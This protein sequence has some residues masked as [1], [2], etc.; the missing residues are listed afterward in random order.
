MNVFSALSGGLGNQMFQYAAARSLAQRVGADLVI[1]TWSGF[2]RDHQYRRHYELGAF[3]IKGR[4]ARPWE[5]IPIWLHRA[6]VRAGFCP[7]QPI[8]DQWFGKFL[9][10]LPNTGSSPTDR[11]AVQFEYQPLF[12]QFTPSR[13]V[14]LLGYWQS[15]RYFEEISTALRME[16]MP[17]MPIR[18]SFRRLGEELSQCESVAL[19]V[20]L[21]EESANPGAHALH[22]RLKGVEEIRSAVSRVRAAHPSARIYVFCTHRSEILAQ[23]NLPADTVH[24]THDEGYT[25][26]VERLWLLTRCQHHVFTNSSFYWWG[27][28]LSAAIRVGATQHI[29]A[30]DNCINR[31]GLCA[32]WDRF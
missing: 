21:Y 23:L 7:T 27:A 30:A 18:D 25:G 24:V 12:H 16:L 6:A 10:E 9:V 26:T 17:P 13:T 11:P 5:R 19:G 22:G 15:P 32:H 2:V 28:W 1:D 4:A 14:W 3:P 29:I 20:R 8:R 31:D